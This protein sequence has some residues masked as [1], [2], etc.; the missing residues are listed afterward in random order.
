MLVRTVSVG[1]TEFILHRRPFPVSLLSGL[2]EKTIKESIKANRFLRVKLVDGEVTI[3]RWFNEFPPARD[4]FTA[5]AKEL[6]LVNA[7]HI[8]WSIK[9][10][11]LRKV[12]TKRVKN[13]VALPME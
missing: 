3:R 4:D 7:H 13:A 8:L 12:Y 9:G 6:G 10:R 2:S 11:P 5:R 1:N